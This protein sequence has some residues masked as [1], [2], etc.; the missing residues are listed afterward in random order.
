MPD[1][2]IAR[3]AAPRSRRADRGQRTPSGNCERTTVMMNTMDIAPRTRP[4]T[5]LWKILRWL[6]TVGESVAERR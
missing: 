5:A 6:K 4:S 3:P 1:I 2:R